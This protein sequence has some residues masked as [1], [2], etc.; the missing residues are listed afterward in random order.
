[1]YSSVLDR[2]ALNKIQSSIIIHEVL[3]WGRE[4]NLIEFIG[5]VVIRSKGLA[6]VDT[7][8]NTPQSKKKEKQMRL[9]FE[10]GDK[11]LFI[12]HKKNRVPS[13][14]AFNSPIFFCHFL[15]VLAISDS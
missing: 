9:N 7:N 3:G 6:K 1:M 14:P 8:Q 12:W 11:I 10:L 2:T 5:L 15:P 4:S 13:F